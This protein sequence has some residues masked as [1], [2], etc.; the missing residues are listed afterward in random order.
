MERTAKTALR[1]LASAVL[2][3]CA[4]LAA[5]AQA[6]PTKAVTLICPWPAGG[7]TDVHLRKLGELASKRLGQAVVIENRPG[8][9]GMNGPSTMSKTAKPDGYT[10]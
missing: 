2:L 10:I 4:P 3:A 9:S 6:Y 1:L 8:G 7:A 5:H